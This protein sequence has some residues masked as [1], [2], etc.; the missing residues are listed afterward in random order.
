MASY[1]AL[2]EILLIYNN[3]KLN[4]RHLSTNKYIAYLASANSGVTFHFS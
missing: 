4:N 2:K 3:N 1:S